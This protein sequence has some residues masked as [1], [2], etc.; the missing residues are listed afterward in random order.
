LDQ[1]GITINGGTPGH[2]WLNV[3]LPGGTDVLMMSAVTEADLEIQVAI[4]ARDI[5]IPSALLTVDRPVGWP[6][7]AAFPF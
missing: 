5:G 7:A 6:L 1:T 2:R 4:L 3:R